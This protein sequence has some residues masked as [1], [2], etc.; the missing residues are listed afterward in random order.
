MLLFD[1]VKVYWYYCIE[2]SIFWNCIKC[3]IKESMP[4]CIMSFSWSSRFFISLCHVLFY[5]LGFFQFYVTF[6]F[7]P[8]V[9]LLLSL[10]KEAVNNDGSSLLV[11]LSIYIICISSRVVAW[12][13]VW[14]IYALLLWY[15]IIHVSIILTRVMALKVY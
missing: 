11:F 10:S 12:S 6:L 15:P 13:Y 8:E 7:Y 4:C 5:F 9:Q 3:S 14:T 2:Y 1:L